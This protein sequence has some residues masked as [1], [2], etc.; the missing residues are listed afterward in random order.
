[1]KSIAFFL[2]LLLSFE[3]GIAVA[4]RLPNQTP[5][6]QIIS[7]DTIIDVVGM[8]S[9]STSLSWVISSPG[10]IPS[11]IL[12]PGQTVASVSY[13]DSIMTNGGH[14]MLNKNFA[15]DS[16]NKGRGLYN[17]EAEKVLTY[18]S[19]EGSHLVGDEEY[20]LSIAGNYA[21]S[22]GAIRCV[23]SQ[24]STATLPAFCSIVSA[25][26]S[27]INVNSAQVSTKGGIRAV[28]STAGVPAELNYQI[29][30]TPDKSSGSEYAE[31]IVRTV[32]AGSV[33]EARDSDATT[34]NRTAVENTWKDTTS[35]SGGIRQFQKVFGY[36]SGFQI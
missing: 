30:I 23:F 26:S 15:F 3:A 25:K 17:I 28:S 13:H 31:G 11:G 33:M 34:W 21:D 6:N 27:L 32:F 36:Q 35:V 9:D 2:I 12:G 18:A 22:N 7:I 16:R 19:T 1:M 20:T 24:G 4:D 5:E 10:S 29:M 14:L 8:V